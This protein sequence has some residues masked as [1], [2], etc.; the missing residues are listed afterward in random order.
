[1]SPFR[2]RFFKSTITRKV[3]RAWRRTAKSERSGLSKQVWQLACVRPAATTAL[4]GWR[5]WLPLRPIFRPKEK[6]SKLS[7]LLFS[8]PNVHRNKLVLQWDR[9]MKNSIRAKPNGK[10]KTGLQERILNHP[11]PT[12]SLFKIKRLSSYELT[13]VFSG[14]LLALQYQAQ[15]HISQVFL[16]H[17]ST[18]YHWLVVSLSSAWPGMTSHVIQEPYG[19]RCWI[20]YVDGN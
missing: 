4:A 3:R 19:T 5:S 14:I 12:L 17:I 18:S 2:S 1:M 13:K 20:E 10:S 8:H 9:V 6:R 15:R 7:F 11:V 16:V